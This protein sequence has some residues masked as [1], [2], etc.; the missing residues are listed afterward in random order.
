MFRI[1]LSVLIALACLFG[2]GWLLLWVFDYVW[3][4]ISSTDDKLSVAIVAGFFSILGAAL[5]VTLGRHF[6]R[7]REIETH[8]R[9]KKIKIYDQFLVE[10]FK[11]FHGTDKSSGDKKEVTA[12][13]REWQRTLVLWGGNNVLRAY[14]AWMSNLK[15][16]KPDVQTIFLMDDF[17][18]ALRRDIGQSSFGI[19]KGEFSHLWLQHADLFLEEAKKNPSLT[20]SELAEIEERRST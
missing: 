11:V 9:E 7:K 2:F 18:R 20:L 6:D 10:L 15:Q 16:A 5:T 4:G 3:S 13:L 1:F 17:F 19:K 8:F 14:F 12:F